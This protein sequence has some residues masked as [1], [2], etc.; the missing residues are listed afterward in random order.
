MNIPV[1]VLG[2]LDEMTLKFIYND[3]LLEVSL[4]N[5]RKEEEATCLTS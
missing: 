2:E 5:F 1:V 3:V 4:R